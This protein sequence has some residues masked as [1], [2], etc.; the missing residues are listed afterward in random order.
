MNKDAAEPFDCRWTVASSKCNYINDMSFKSLWIIFRIVLCCS[1]ITASLA[2]TA[3]GI[4]K[5]LSVR[6]AALPV[7]GCITLC[8]LSVHPSICPSP[9]GLLLKNERSQ[10]VQIRWRYFLVTHKY[11]WQRIFHGV[12]QRSRSQRHR[13]AS[14]LLKEYFA[15]SSLTPFLCNFNR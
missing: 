3:T 5:R 9:P 13:P 2:H 4:N 8:T 10:K 11:N 12:G 6:Y 14:L 15:L 7:G 1:Q